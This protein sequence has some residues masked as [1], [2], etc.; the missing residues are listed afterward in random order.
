MIE[1]HAP[2]EA[3]H[4][5]SDFFIHIDTIAIG[6]LLAIG[7]EQSVEYV[8]HAHERRELRAALYAE[9]AQIL[10]D[11][12]GVR[13]VCEADRLEN[14]FRISQLRA[15]RDKRPVPPE[16]KI[17]KPPADLPNDPIWQA[18]KASGTTALLGREEQAAYGELNAMCL[19]AYDAEVAIRVARREVN[20]YSGEFVVGGEDYATAFSHA[21]RAE[22]QEMIKLLGSLDDAEREEGYIGSMTAGAAE[23]VHNGERD[24][25]K[26]YAAEKSVNKGDNVAFAPSLKIAQTL[27]PA[28]GDRPAE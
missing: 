24:L 23:S 11:S 10:K 12:R 13:K 26:I 14:N 18:S 9:S 25:T 8:H 28:G 21:S 1:V 20:A 17:N 22:I 27:P 3:T 6:L 15:I 16:P 19:Q 4:T 2:H 5:W 7:L